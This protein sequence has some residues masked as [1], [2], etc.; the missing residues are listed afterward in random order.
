MQLIVTGQLHRK[1]M[2]A[3]RQNTEEEYASLENN[4]SVFWNFYQSSLS[5]FH[6]ELQGRPEGRTWDICWQCASKCLLSSRQLI[7]SLRWLST[8]RAIL[9]VKSWSTFHGTYFFSRIRCGSCIGVGR[10]HEKYG[11]TFSRNS[12]SLLG[13]NNE[14]FQ[15][16]TNL[17][18]FLLCYFLW[19]HYSI[20]QSG[21]HPLQ[22]SSKGMARSSGVS[23]FENA[24]TDP[25]KNENE[26]VIAM[27]VV[28]SNL[29]ISDEK[30]T[31]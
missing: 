24:Q 19:L 4:N 5:C 12:G 27:D 10:F 9:F 11:P 6:T 26:A 17:K 23:S 29:N 15:P 2:V 7:P 8:V 16:W 13:K 14:Q 25:S 18:L 31:Q 30:S 3:W 28:P 1:I 22:P 21:Q 20:F